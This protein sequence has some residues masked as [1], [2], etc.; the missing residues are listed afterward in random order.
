MTVQLH[1]RPVDYGVPL[2]LKL[3]KFAAFKQQLQV[4]NTITHL[5]ILVTKLLYSASVYKSYI[6]YINLAA[7]I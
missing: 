2:V 3:V 1:L 7:V 5:L 4:F 6:R